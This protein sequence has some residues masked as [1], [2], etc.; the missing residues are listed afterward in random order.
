LYL[1]GWKL[2][3]S[4]LADLKT[5]GKKRGYIEKQELDINQS[6]TPDLSNLTS[7]EIMNILKLA[8]GE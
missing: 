5:K 2:L 6:N 8:D 7:E 3:I 1:F 4:F